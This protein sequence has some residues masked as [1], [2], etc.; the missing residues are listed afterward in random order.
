METFPSNWANE[1]KKNKSDGFESRLIV[2][3]Q[4]SAQICFPIFGYYAIREYEESVI[5][6]VNIYIGK[7]ENVIL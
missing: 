4:H 7:K 1:F 2:F 3:E 6:L 5:R